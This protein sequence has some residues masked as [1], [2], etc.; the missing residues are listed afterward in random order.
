MYGNNAG[1]NYGTGG[2]FTV[3][4]GPYT[5]ARG[6]NEFWGNLAVFDGSAAFLSRSSQLTG[7]SDGKTFSFSF[8]VR[9]NEAATTE[10]L[11]HIYNGSTLY[12]AMQRDSTDY[13]SFE[14]RNSSAIRILNNV[15]S[16][17]AM[18]SSSDTYCVQ[19]C[20]D[21]NDTAKRFVY[22][23]GVLQTS[24]WSDYTNGV[25][26]FTNPNIF[27]ASNNTSGSFNLF[28]RLSEFYFTTDYIDFSQEANR[29]K[30]RDAFGN[31]TDLPSAIT[32]GSVPNPAIYMRFPPTT[33]GTN[34]GTGGNFTVNGTIT[35]GGQL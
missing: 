2:D 21:L 17:T 13:L 1:R 9:F 7:I 34:S 24:N 4:S 15:A 33:F 3:N 29:L 10:R 6:P 26:D 19:I 12:F 22:I 5:G 8:F 18:S 31:P 27:I 11:F 16:T 25:I 14:A 32:A 28:G 35:D 23:N 20:V 30:F